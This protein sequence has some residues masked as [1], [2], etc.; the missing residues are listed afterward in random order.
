MKDARC[1]LV[2]QSVGQV[3][4]LAGGG[5]V[6]RLG[7]GST[8][9]PPVGMVAVAWVGRPR[10]SGMFETVGMLETA[11]ISEMLVTVGTLRLLGRVGT[12]GML[13]GLEVRAGRLYWLKGVLSRVVEL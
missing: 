11:E 1:W 10:V 7:G 9:T 3:G 6:G 12:I 13:T 2:V 4:G 8:R 5:L